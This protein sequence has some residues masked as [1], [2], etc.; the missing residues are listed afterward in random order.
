MLI[1]LIYVHANLNKGASGGDVTGIAT[2]N[3]A[4]QGFLERIDISVFD[5]RV[6]LGKIRSHIVVHQC[7]VLRIDTPCHTNHPLHFE[8]FMRCNGPI[9]DAFYEFLQARG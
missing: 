5:G 8:K 1:L 2:V 7:Y 4:A 9:F 3:G 6:E